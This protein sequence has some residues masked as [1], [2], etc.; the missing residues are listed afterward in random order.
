MTNA[1]ER[2][3]SALSAKNLASKVAT[4]GK[5]KKIARR[6]VMVG[7]AAHKYRRPIFWPLSQF[8]TGQPRPFALISAMA[9]VVSL[10][11]GCGRDPAPAA[12]TTP[13]STKIQ[14]GGEIVASLRA[15]PRSL[16]RFAA[17]DTGTALFA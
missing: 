9:V 1:G 4:P 13:A 6:N 7:P 12:T 3:P 15:E 16:N 2:P 11:A 17:R 8:L 14:P 10:T 5:T